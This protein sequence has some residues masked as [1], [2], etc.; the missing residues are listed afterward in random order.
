MAEADIERQ[1]VEHVATRTAAVAHDE[2]DID[3]GV[4]VPL[5]SRARAEQTGFL[6]AGPSRARA[7]AM[8]SRIAAV[9]LAL[10]VGGRG[11]SEADGRGV[12]VVKSTVPYARMMHARRVM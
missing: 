5:T 11:T 1:I 8:N 2:S 10:S 9:S 12:G 6:S 4:L 3:I 7:A